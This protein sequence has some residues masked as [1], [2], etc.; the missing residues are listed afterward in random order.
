MTKNEDSRVTELISRLQELHIEQQQILIELEDRITD[1]T[2]SP[3]SSTPERE[4]EVGDT[5]RFTNNYRREYGLRGV[6]THL[7]PKT[8]KIKTEKGD[9]I[10]KY[11]NIERINKP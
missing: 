6:I 7:N 1:G 4:Y 9:R 5:V 2:T 11:S 10:K 3:K 8:A